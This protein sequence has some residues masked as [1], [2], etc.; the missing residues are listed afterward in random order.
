MSAREPTCWGVEDAEDPPT[1]ADPGEAAFD[2]LYKCGIAVGA[3]RETDF[4]EV[5]GYAPCIPVIDT[6]RLLS[7]VLEA[8][9]EEYGDE[10]H[11]YTDATPA[12]LA[13]GEVFVAAILAE[14]NPWTCDVVERRQVRVLDWVREHRP[15]WLTEVA[16]T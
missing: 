11:G 7:G 4:V 10:E 8:L 12:M 2:Y 13:A 16:H 6:D 15:E 5:C 1:F 14:Y 9:D 3:I